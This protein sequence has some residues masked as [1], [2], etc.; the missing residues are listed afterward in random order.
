ME[1]SSHFNPWLGAGAFVR[2]EIAAQANPCQCHEMLPPRYT[3][4]N[5][6]LHDMPY[7]SNCSWTTAE[8]MPF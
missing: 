4:E 5:R 6:H 8:E 7:F 2:V 3:D 1:E